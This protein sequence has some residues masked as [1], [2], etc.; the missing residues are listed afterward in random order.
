V[1]YFSEWLRN[2]NVCTKYWR[3]FK[4]IFNMNLVLVWFII[5]LSLSTEALAHVVF[6]TD[7]IPEEYIT[8][9]TARFPQRG[10][11]RPFN[12]RSAIQEHRPDSG[13]NYRPQ[14]RS[15]SSRSISPSEDRPSNPRYY[16]HKRNLRDSVNSNPQL[17]PRVTESDED[18]ERFALEPNPKHQILETQQAEEKTSNKGAEIEASNLDESY[19]SEETDPESYNPCNNTVP[20]DPDDKVVSEETDPE[21]YNPCNTTV[22][23]VP[24]NNLDMNSIILIVGCIFATTIIVTIGGLICY[25]LCKKYKAAAD[26]KYSATS[27]KNKSLP[28]GK[29]KAG[30][31]TEL[32]HFHY[33]RNILTAAEIPTAMEISAAAESSNTSVSETDTEN[34]SEC[35]SALFDHLK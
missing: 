34:T 1:Y 31:S 21:S 7:E 18:Y 26:V 32:Y 12:S 4:V 17:F 33:Q 19:S 20:A 27:S 28:E 8:E 5:Y 10:W 14:G 24:D 2:E 6:Y 23:L 22:P 25:M 16:E 11:H 35:D 9:Q 13:L 30:Q 29:R 15:S 3:L